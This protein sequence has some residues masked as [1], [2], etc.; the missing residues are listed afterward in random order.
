MRAMR[1][2]AIAGFMAALLVLP[3]VL[4]AQAPTKEHEW[5][6]QLAGQWDADLEIFAEPG[7]PPMKLK[8]TEDT[9]RIGGY[10]ILSEG[11]VTGSPMPF[12]RAL[13]LGYD[14]QKKKYV[15]TWMDSNSPNLGIYEGSLDEA[16]KTL[17]LEGDMPS[18][19]A[20][21]ATV[22]MRQVIE[23]KSPDRK[24]LT[25]SVQGP[26]GNWLTLVTLDARR[27]K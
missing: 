13:T 25:T 2:T 6:H 26:D 12:K 14:P 4:A 27:K 17:T 7:K 9:R 20:P 23:I 21:G 5:L 11:E 3:T 24:V 19:F 18:P 22:R 16:G 10:W 8:S 15:A 1:K